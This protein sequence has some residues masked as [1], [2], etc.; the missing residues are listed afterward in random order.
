MNKDDFASGLIN[1]AHFCQFPPDC[2]TDGGYG[3]SRRL[4][5]DVAQT[6]FFA[7]REFRTFQEFTLTDGQTHVVKVVFNTD[8]IVFGL[9]VAL[10]SGQVKVE[11]IS[12]GTGGGSFSTTLPIFARNTMA[13][14]PSPA[15]S[16][17]NVITSGGTVS[18]GTEIDVLLNK[19]AANAN[20]AASI[21]VGAADETG[22]AAGTYYLKITATGSAQGVL[23][24]R[25]EERP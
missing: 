7:G 13:E 18:G 22:F 15:Y 5:V 14:A 16:A 19:T 25:W 23:K 20:F 11:T 8:T 9:D 24:I 6:G 17:L 12:G 4:R 3:E 21:G 1:T 2:Y 10:L